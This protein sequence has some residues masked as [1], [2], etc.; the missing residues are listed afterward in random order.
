MPQ[1][2]LFKQLI[3]SSEVTS[4]FF[5]ML[6]R[7]VSCEQILVGSHKVGRIDHSRVCDQ[8]GADLERVEQVKKFCPLLHVKVG[9]I[10]FLIV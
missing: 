1:G 7:N 2:F 4:A 10:C 8:F 6:N 3:N 5:R 9:R